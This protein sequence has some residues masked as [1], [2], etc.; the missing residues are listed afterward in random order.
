MDEHDDDV[1]GG[2][3]TS[4]SSRDTPS[5]S[6]STRAS[7]S[8]GGASSSRGGVSS[9][10]GADNSSGASASRSTNK[11]KPFSSFN[12]PKPQQTSTPKDSTSHQTSP[13]KML[14]KK[15]GASPKL[16]RILTPPPTPTPPP[17][18]PA[19][20]QKNNGKR[21]TS[22]SFCNPSFDSTTS[23]LLPNSPHD[24]T[25]SPSSHQ[26]E[27]E[28]NIYEDLNHTNSAEHLDTSEDLELSIMNNAGNYYSLYYPPNSTQQVV[29]L[30]D[31]K[32]P[33]IELSS[34]FM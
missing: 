9:S 7:S 28:S 29:N 12:P 24:S 10:R 3:T 33:P 20:P 19:L 31:P 22:Q 8:R 4:D 25:P 6:N 17:P 15:N 34:V 30:I 21:N 2:Q 14:A 13:K 26:Q 23:T 32:I 16:G 11:A 27:S 18:P 1:E 5:G